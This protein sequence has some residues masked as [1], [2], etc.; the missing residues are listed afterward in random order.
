M[1]TNQVDIAEADLAATS[2]RE[3]PARRSRAV[4]YLRVSTTSQVNTD[5]DPELSLGGS[6]TN[7][8]AWEG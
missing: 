2:S 6:T 1:A 8:P 7:R 5:Y 4:S 3:G